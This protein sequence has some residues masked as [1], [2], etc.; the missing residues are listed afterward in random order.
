MKALSDWNGG[1][2]VI[3]HDE[4][5][6]T[7]VARELWVCGD[8]T[9]SKF[10]GDVQAYKASVLRLVLCLLITDGQ[11]SNSLSAMSRPSPKLPLASVG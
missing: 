4:R 1:V 7:H 3:S 10:H 9:V 6:I 5:F 11:Y 2:I 8:G